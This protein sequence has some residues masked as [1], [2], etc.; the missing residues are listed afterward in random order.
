M[1]A[2][3]TLKVEGV[4]VTVNEAR[5]WDEGLPQPTIRVSQA[6]RDPEQ[7]RATEGIRIERPSYSANVEVRGL[8]IKSSQS[9]NGYSCLERGRR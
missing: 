2:P 7:T 8:G 1:A 6:H 9:V 4:A 5:V 3:P